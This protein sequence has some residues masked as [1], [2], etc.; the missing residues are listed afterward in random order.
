MSKLT[1]DDLPYDPE[2]FVAAVKEL[3]PRLQLG[4]LEICAEALGMGENE[5]CAF[6]IMD[7]KMQRWKNDP[8]DFNRDQVVACACLIVEARKLDRV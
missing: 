8:S 1:T 3:F 6:R 7:V 4:V 5:Y 2:S